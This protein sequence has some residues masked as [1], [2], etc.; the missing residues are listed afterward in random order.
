MNWYTIWWKIGDKFGICFFSVVLL[1]KITEKGKKNEKETN[2]GEKRN[3]LFD[4]LF[5]WMG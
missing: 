3:S 4:I 1:L 5:I 2:E